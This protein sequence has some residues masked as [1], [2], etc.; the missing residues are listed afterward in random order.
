MTE[1]S[2]EA[3]LRTAVSRHHRPPKQNIPTGPLEIVILADLRQVSAQIAT[4][5]A[6]ILAKISGILHE[7]FTPDELRCLTAGMGID[8]HDIDGSTH[9]HKC[10][11][12]V[13]YCDRR[14]R[15][16]DLLQKIQ[17]QRPQTQL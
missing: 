7:Y 4:I 10:A 14:Q 1:K 3:R 9:A 17:D 13:E 5:E 16:P 8:Y 6:Y 12:L 11:A 15:L 2:G